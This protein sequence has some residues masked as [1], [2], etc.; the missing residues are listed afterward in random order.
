MSYFSKILLTTTMIAICLST[1]IAL[2][3]ES[4]TENPAALKILSSRSCFLESEE[5]HI[6]YSVSDPV[7]E[8][9]GLEWALV[10]AGRTLAHG[11]SGSTDIESDTVLA[12]IYNIAV[13]MPP[14][15]A[16]IVLPAELQVT[17]LRNK[18]TRR[19][20][21]SIYIFSRNPFAAQ[22]AFLEEA[23]IKLFDADG[24]TAELLDKN[25]IPHSRLLNLSAIDLVTEGIV[26]VGEGAS[27]RKQ[28]K[29][30]ESLLRVAQRE[31]PVLCLAPSEGDFSL[32][33]RQDG[34]LVRPSRLALERG[35]VVRR[36]DKRFDEIPIAC[37]LSLESLR[38]KVV[39][40]AVDGKDD[41]AWADMEFSAEASEKPPG[42]LIVCGLGIVTHWEESPVSRYLFV[43][44]LEELTR[45]Q[46]TLEKQKN[47][48]TQ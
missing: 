39:L 17:W 26:L 45:A 23:Q 25:E 13:R 9:E 35:D 36:Y 33:I 47:V 1:N 42:R 14:L 46:S 27:F 21:R 43:R 16:G 29:L 34:L 24:R 40:S 48:F 20:K 31:V 8:D 41:W 28:R 5:A 18:Q 38:N 37:H 10:A 32:A 15:R 6:T 2:G 11:S 19:T 30:A 44:L 3:Q 12:R 22:Q 7:E 4:R